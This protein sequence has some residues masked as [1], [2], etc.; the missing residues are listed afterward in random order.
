MDARDAAGRN[1]LLGIRACV[2][3]VAL[4]ESGLVPHL[5]GHH[6]G[7]RIPGRRAC[8]RFRIRVCVRRAEFHRNPGRSEMALN[9]SQNKASSPG[10][11][12]RRQGS[13]LVAAEY[14]G[15]TVSQMTAMRVKACETGVYLKVVK[16]TLAGAPWKA[17]DFAVVKGP[18]VGPLLYA[19]STEEP[20]AAGRLIKDSQRAND[21]LKPKLV[22]SAE[23][24]RPG[25]R[26]S[27]GLAADPRAGARR[28]LV[29]PRAG[30]TAGMFARGQGRGRPA[31][32]GD[33]LR[34]PKPPPKPEPE[35]LRRFDVFVFNQTA[36]L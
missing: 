4:L 8:R 34:L 23:A 15:T 10:G 22:A 26:R 32:G 35:S 24:L 21:K 13:V 25:A 9:L 31:G 6:R 11:E 36:I 16:N 29:L 17:P 3:G 18:M 33:A 28:M 14:A 19:F 2:D 1:P 30:R 7:W 27:A 5:D 12:C 20:G